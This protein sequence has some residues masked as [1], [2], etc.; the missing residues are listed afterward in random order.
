MKILNVLTV[1][2]LLF[3]STKI[4]SCAGF[5]YSTYYLESG[6]N[7]LD[8]G[9]VKDAI[10]REL[11]RGYAYN[12]RVWE[13]RKYKQKVNIA[14]WAEFLH[15]SKE[16]TKKAV[17]EHAMLKDVDVSFRIYIDYVYANMELVNNRASWDKPKKKIDKSR[18]NAAI[19]R[20]EGLLKNEK[21]DFLRL[22][23]VY[24]IIRLAHYSQQ[25]EKA[26]AL[27]NRYVPALKNIKSS[28]Q[29]RIM[30]L[31]A[32]ALMHLGKEAEASYLFARLFESSKTHRYLAYLNFHIST[33]ESW[34]ALMGMCKSPDEKAL[35]YF[36]RALK[37]K[38]NSLEELASIYQIAPNSKWFDVL[39]LRELEYIQF[40]IEVKYTPNNTSS[41]YTINKTHL[42]DE[43]SRYALTQPPATRRMGYVFIL[44]SLL[45]NVHRKDMF[46]TAFAKIYIQFLSGKQIDADTLQGFKTQFQ[47]DKRLNLI[48]PFEL[49]VYLDTLRYIDAKVEKEITTR[50][51]AIR[52]LGLK[53]VVL[54][55]NFLTY[56]FVKIA[57][58]YQ[59]KAKQYLCQNT[60]G[61]DGD[62]V[63]VDTVKEIQQ[64]MLKKDKSFLETSMLRGVDAFL[65]R[66]TLDE[67][68]GKIYLQ[69]EQYDKAV[70]AFAKARLKPLKYNP[71]NASLNGTNRTA[72]KR[73]LTL[74][75][76]ARKLQTIKKQANTDAM[77]AFLY[78][79]ARY[80]MS[81]FGNSPMSVRFYRSTV[82][83]D[84]KDGSMDK[85]IAYYQKALSLSSDRELNAKILY[86]L[87]KCELNVRLQTRKKVYGS[88]NFA[89]YAYAKKQLAPDVAALKKEGYGEYYK[90][91]EAYKDTAYFKE[92]IKQCKVYNAY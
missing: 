39:L 8:R 77:N 9:L 40:P 24:N 45:Q 59:D 17:Y 13:E 47:K 44:Q 80:N 71:F 53:D 1:V 25:Y 32:G 76:F 16:D 4:F 10:A 91:I 7:V 81:W 89:G 52:A 56:V 74:L 65:E 38:A 2:F 61:F 82:S 28:I 84:V 88:W 36:I 41:M 90:A 57:P 79:T 26:L 22:R 48:K 5:G 60:A 43:L 62:D 86:N 15:L 66:Y 11:S 12:D 37:P 29:A 19:A 23:Y 67:V 27:Y 83:W 73:K 58:L 92:V 51:E 69:N 55:E 42:I 20:G 75:D 18:Y 49:M 54:Q 34:Q 64:L 70:K 68:L 21:S 3:F 30:S 85:A 63:D 46:L 31:K 50:L 33:D 87:A 72:S 14:E 78:A 6:Y 35:M